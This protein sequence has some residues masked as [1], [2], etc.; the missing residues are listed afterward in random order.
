LRLG[1]CN[2]V[3]INVSVWDIRFIFGEIEQADENKLVMTDR[4]RVSM[5][6]AHAKVFSE[7]LVRNIQKYE[8]VFGE[9]KIQAAENPN[10]VP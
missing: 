1:L 3:N 4:V 7:V 10:P 2:L 5:S 6:P 9:I 8:E